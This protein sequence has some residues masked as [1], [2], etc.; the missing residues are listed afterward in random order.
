[1]ETFPKINENCNKTELSRKC[2]GLLTSVSGLELGY[3]IGAIIRNKR[4]LLCH[5]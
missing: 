4:L 3:E 5:Y 1:M 2:T